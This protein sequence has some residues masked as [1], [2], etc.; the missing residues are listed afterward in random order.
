MNVSPGRP[1]M[2]RLGELIKRKAISPK[3]RALCLIVG[4][5]TDNY[6]LY[7][8]SLKSIQVVARCV[9]DG[10]YAKHPECE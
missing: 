3:A 2:F 7:N 8:L 9:I 6:T 10:L 1:E 5:D 4:E